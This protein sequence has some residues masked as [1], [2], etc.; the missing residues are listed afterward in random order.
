MSAPRTVGALRRR[1]TLE[2]PVETADDIGGVTRSFSALANVWGEIS[3]STGQRLF[4][5]QRAEEDI[6]HLIR[7]RWRDGM[8]AKLRLR[9]GPRIFQ[10]RAAFDPDER[11]RY[12]HCLCREIK[13]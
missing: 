2:A 13:P 12:L 8:S 9:L 5:A 6:S 10:I 4:V 7:I 3:P 1:L 11:R